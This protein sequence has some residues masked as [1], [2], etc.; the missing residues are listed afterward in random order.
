[1]KVINFIGYSDKTE[2]MLYVAKIV[3]SF[4][5]NV[6][7]IDSIST[8]KCRYIIPTIEEEG[9]VKDK[10]IT[11]F[12]DIDIAIGFKSKKEIV[13]YLNEYNEDFNNYDYVFI[14]TN[15]EQMCS[16]FDVVNAN[17]TFCITTYDRQDIIKTSVL[18]QI[19]Q[20]NKQ[21]YIEKI[22]INRV[23]W[24]TL[25]NA[26][27]TKYI[28]VDFKALGIEWDKKDVYIP[29]DE[30]D[31]TIVIQNQ[32][33]EKMKFKELSKMFKKALIEM[34]EII[35]PEQTNATITKVFKNIERRI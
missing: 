35:M 21:D 20:E 30:N 34:T 22:N 28:D 23:Y 9:N 32:Y 2:I 25:L 33:S 10:Y 19:L 17:T 8:Q 24:Y 6:L 11:T 16:D 1:M 14:D 7:Y 5:N 29:L 13:D 15:T 3:Q 27:E 26:A 12:E 31:K 4:G 18:M